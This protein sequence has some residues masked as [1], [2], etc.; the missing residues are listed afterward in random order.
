[1]SWFSKITH[2]EGLTPDFIKKI[3]DV[4]A[5]LV[6]NAIPGGNTLNSVLNLTNQGGRPAMTPSQIAAQTGQNLQTSLN[7]ATQ[8]GAAQSQGN[9]IFA[10]LSTPMGLILIAIAAYAILKKKG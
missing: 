8:F 3:G 2:T 7:A 5:P 6:L 10:A 4:A 1:M 9:Q